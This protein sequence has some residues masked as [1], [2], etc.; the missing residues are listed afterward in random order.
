MNTGKQFG[1][2]MA[3]IQEQVASNEKKLRK[4]KGMKYQYQK[5]TISLGVPI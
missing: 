3:S 1:R 4:L 2:D 5:N